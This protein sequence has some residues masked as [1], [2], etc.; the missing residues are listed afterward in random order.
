MIKSN[1]LSFYRDKGF[2]VFMVSVR[3][4]PTNLKNSK[5]I[6]AKIF[7]DRV[8][9]SNPGGLP[10]GLSERDF[11]RRAVRRNQLI[12]SLL[13]RIDFVEN[14]G[15]G[16]NKIRTFLKA[17]GL[18]PPQFEFGDFY[19]IIFRSKQHRP[20]V[21]RKVSGKT[22]VKTRVETRVETPVETKLK[23][24]DIIL[25][26]LSAH[27]NMTLSEL[28]KKIGRAVSTV[29]RAASKLVR[30]GRLRRIGPKKVGYWKVINSE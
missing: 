4:C 17:A 8:E 3:T 25:D 29:E 12:A 10:R 20:R 15:T 7:D 22:R 5:N 2:C 9:I 28:A 16:I 26:I 27:P 11:G 24:P 13:H 18:P 1:P 21:E 6:C 14:M 23:T 19:T 30:E